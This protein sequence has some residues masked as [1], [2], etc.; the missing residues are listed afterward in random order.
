M[1]LS[2]MLGYDLADEIVKKVS[3]NS[4]RIYKNIDGVNVRISD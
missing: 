1:G 4:K 2:E 3:K